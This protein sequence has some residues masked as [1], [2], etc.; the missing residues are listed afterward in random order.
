MANICDSY[1]ET[2]NSNS[3]NIFPTS[4]DG[5]AQSFTGNGEILDSAKW[6]IKK[7]GSPSGSIFS[8]I[9]ATTGSFGT[10]SKPTGS[11]LATSDAFDISTLTTSFALN[12][13]NFSGANRI[14]LTNGTKYCVSIESAVGTSPNHLIVS[15]DSTAPTH[16]GN[17]SQLAGGSWAAVSTFDMVFYVLTVSAVTFTSRLALLGMG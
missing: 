15:F 4:A 10:T 9:Y 8:K 12:I 5:D 2:N 17:Y 6:Y 14:T 16:A 13:F 1:S 7:T 11:A 3:D